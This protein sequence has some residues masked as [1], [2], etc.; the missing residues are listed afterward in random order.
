MTITTR[1]KAELF[2]AELAYSE[3]LQNFKN[4][5]PHGVSFLSETVSTEKATACIRLY[6]AQAAFNALVMLVD[7]KRERSSMI[8]TVDRLISRWNKAETNGEMDAIQQEYFSL[9][10]IRA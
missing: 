10:S 7:P 9:Y 3:A 5:Y 4:E 8:A 2:D 6:E 1:I